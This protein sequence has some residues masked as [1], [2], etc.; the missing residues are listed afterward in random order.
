MKTLV[1]GNSSFVGRFVCVCPTGR[2]HS[3]A[4][5]EHSSVCW[6]FLATWSFGAQLDF[7]LLSLLL[8]MRHER[9]GPNWTSGEQTS[10]LRRTLA[11]VTTTPASTLIAERNAKKENKT[12]IRDHRRR[13]KHRL[14]GQKA[15]SFSCIL[16]HISWWLWKATVVYKRSE[17]YL[18]MHAIVWPAMNL[19]T[20][21]EFREKTLFSLPNHIFCVQFFSTPSLNECGLMWRQ[22]DEEE[23]EK[24]RFTSS[25]VGILCVGFTFALPTPFLPN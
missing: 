11:A 20:K 23:E 9:N 5:V 4:A 24:N 15:V 16:A 22:H 8:A 6:L 19:R 2:L 14:F 10:N 7:R 21:G 3:L 1:V 12:R 17:W 18:W 25:M 13:H